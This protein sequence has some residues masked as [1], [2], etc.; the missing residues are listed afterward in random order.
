M[1]T[2]TSHTIVFTG[3]GSAGH[4][5]PNLPLISRCLQNNWKVFYIGSQGGIEKNIIE[6]EKI[7]YF[8]IASGKLR[9]YFSWQ[10]FTDPL[11]ILIGVVQS[12]LILRKL[13]PHVIFSKGGFVS[14]PV[15]IAGKLLGIPSIVHESDLTPGLSNRLCFP[16]AQKICLTF[17]ET[18]NFIPQ[19]ASKASALGMII[20]EEAHEADAEKGR[21]ICQFPT[22]KKI[23]FVYAGSLGSERINQ[24]LHSALPELLNHFYIIHSCGKGNL[25]TELQQPGYLQFEYLHE[26]FYHLL[27]CADLV[28]SRS[29]SNTLCELLM[30]Q[31][32]HILIPLSQRAS[33]GEQVFNARYFS[34]RGTSIVL[35]E[36][37]L[38][39]TQLIA[40]INKALDETTRLRAAME[41]YSLIDGT[42]KIYQL[43][44]S[45]G[46]S[47][48]KPYKKVTS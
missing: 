15:V 40:A 3:G 17:S 4:V 39:K 46:K 2:Q 1:P 33:R 10:N 19:Y 11:R 7:P 25:H 9:R 28:I 35:D 14:F 5:T 26:T 12:F 48:P 43:I 42:E 45:I 23:L 30:F 20:R 6:K 13:K 21:Q 16:V 38:D 41:Q 22:D 32:P 24:I 44:T 37:H 31:K 8:P 18:L 29:G 34:K 47:L 27:A 36:E